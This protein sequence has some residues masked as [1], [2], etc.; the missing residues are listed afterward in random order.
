MERQGVE[1]KKFD[2]FLLSLAFARDINQRYLGLTETQL[3]EQTRLSLSSSGALQEQD[4]RL[5]MR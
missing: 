2:D 4:G 3:A 5:F 1:T